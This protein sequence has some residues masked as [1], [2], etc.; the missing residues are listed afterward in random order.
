MAVNRLFD[1]IHKLLNEK[2]AIFEAASR[3]SNG[4]YICPLPYERAMYIALKHQ[5]IDD[6]INKLYKQIDEE[7]A[8][9]GLT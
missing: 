6:K 8:E 7:Y 5:E 9:A 4:E 3:D 2:D 1:D